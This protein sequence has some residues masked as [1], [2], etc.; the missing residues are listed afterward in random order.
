[1][2]KA[3]GSRESCTK[4]SSRGAEDC[5][6]ADGHL[7][8]DRVTGHGDQELLLLPRALSLFTLLLKETAGAPPPP[9]LENI[10]RRNINED[11]PPICPLSMYCLSF[12]GVTWQSCSQSWLTLDQKAGHTLDRSLWAED[13]SSDFCSL[14]VDTID[15]GP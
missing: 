1:M 12:E 5:S 3:A 6:L 13:G 11:N 9:W 14:L 4:R 10:V 15:I 7:V 8:A 2:R